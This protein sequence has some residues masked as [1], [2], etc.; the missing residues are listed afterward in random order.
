MY[1]LINRFSEDIDLILD[2]R[3]FGY[4]SGEKDP[5]ILR[6]SKTKQDRFNKEIIRSSAYYVEKSFVPHISNVF[7][8]IDGLHVQISSS[9]L[10]L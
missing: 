3:L 1:K 7:S 5:Y 2:W 9:V 8:D 10:Q 4:G 6:S